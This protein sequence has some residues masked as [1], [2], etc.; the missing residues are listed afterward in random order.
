MSARRRVVEA[1]RGKRSAPEVES[2]RVVVLPDEEADDS[3][4][5][6]TEFDDRRAEYQRGDF[7]F[8][9][10]RAEAEVTINGIAQTLVSG[11]LYGVESDLKEYIE[12]VAQDEYNDL[13]KILT[14]I[15]VSTSRLPQKIERG[16][17]QWR[18]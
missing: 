5:D 3:Y 6:Q 17:I 18:T 1:P 4:L 11:G 9:G 13:R 14:S 16:W 8:V 2:I 10:V 7:H 15:G 12:E